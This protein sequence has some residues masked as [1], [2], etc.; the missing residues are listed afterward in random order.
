MKSKKTKICTECGDEFPCYLNGQSLYTRSCC[1]KCYPLHG[2]QE[3]D[4]HK[5]CSKCHSVKPSKEFHRYKKNGKLSG[6]CQK[7]TTENASLFRQ[8]QKQRAVDYKGGKCCV[9]SYNKTNECLTFHH[10]DPKKKDSEV[11]KMRGL[12]WETLRKE[13]D[14]CILVCCRCHG[15][16]HAGVTP[17]PT[18]PSSHP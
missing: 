9:C 2:E 14:K 17:C 18:L 11:S 5:K 13:L 4:G 1:L 6:W 8:Q 16:I 7:C 3:I 15:E 12:P 10:L